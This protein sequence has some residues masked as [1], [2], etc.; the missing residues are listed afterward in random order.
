MARRQQP[1]A[2]G[3]GTRF[4]LPAVAIFSVALVIRLVHLWQIRRAPFFAVL[5]GDSRTYDAWAQQIAR[6]DWMGQDV[7]Y[8][9]PLYPYFLGAMYGLLGRDL[10]VVRICQAVIG[11]LACVLV[12]LAAC[13]L[14]SKLAGVIA[15]FMLALYAPAIFFDSLLQKTLL[16]VFFICLMLWLLSRLL[17]KPPSGPWPWFW[18]GVA[19]GGLSLTRENALIFA[20]VI[21]GWTIVRAWGSISEQRR[22]AGSVLLGL[23][24]VLLP[25]LGRNWVVG[26]EFYLTTAQFGPNFYIGNNPRATGT[27]APLRQGRGSAEYEREDATALA[28]QSLHRPLSPSEVSSYWTGEA[29]TFIRSQPLAWMRLLGRKVALLWNATEMMDTESQQT[30]AE[31]S[32]PIWLTGSVG[33]FG[34]L[35][36]LALLGVWVTWFRR[37]ELWVLYVLMLAYAATVVLFYVFARYRYPLVPFLVLF[38]SAGLAGSARFLRSRSALHVAAALGTVIALAIFVNRPMLATDLMQ[39][40][41]E[42]NLGEALQ[43]DGKYEEAI[44]HYRRAIALRPDWAPPHNNIGTALQAQGLSDQAVAHFERALSLQPDYPRAHFNLGIALLAQGK[45]LQAIEQFREALRLEPGNARA[46]VNLSTALLDVERFKE[47]A[48]ESRAALALESDAADAHNNL[49]VALASQGALEEAIV[50]FQQALEL[51]PDFADAK[52]NLDNAL[53]IHAQSTTR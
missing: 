11:S 46:H 28:E 7:F 6:G 40:V 35:V 2:N 31:W 52:Q 27:Y 33:H 8:Q 16:D 43:Q 13:R 48:D 39:A 47:A 32:T 20:V 5:M 19:M 17:M 21:L 53:R 24:I 22:T 51:L 44:Q 25:V 10:S 45:S 3:Q 23:A 14:F 49:G 12:G 18:L 34:V 9:A 50:H 30:H 41:T 26:G 15:G 4:F 37:R 1:T 29:L 42:S 36:P 38:A